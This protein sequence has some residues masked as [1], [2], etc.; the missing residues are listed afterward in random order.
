LFHF[1]WTGFVF[2][3]L[4]MPSCFVYVFVYHQTIYLIF[5]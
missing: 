3:S 2:F 4:T 5:L 1:F